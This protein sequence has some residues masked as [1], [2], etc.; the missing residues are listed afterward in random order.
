MCRATKPSSQEKS[1][2]PKTETQANRRPADF[3]KRRAAQS[4]HLDLD[5]LGSDALQLYEKGS[6]PGLTPSDPA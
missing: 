4:A 3:F 2:N 6:D 1:F 5:G